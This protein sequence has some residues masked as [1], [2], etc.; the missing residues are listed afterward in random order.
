MR[1]DAASVDATTLLLS[2][3]FARALRVALLATVA[4]GCE[5]EPSW[6]RAADGFVRVSCAPLDGV[7]T[8]RP[9]D[10]LALR[11]LSVDDWRMPLTLAERGAPC[12]SASDADGCGAALSAVQEL[13]EGEDPPVLPRAFVSITRGDEVAHHDTPEELAG[14]L[15]S[16]DH[17][18]EAVLAARV[19]GHFVTCDEGLEQG[20]VRSV[21][22]GFE[23]VAQRYLS[24]CPAQRERVLMHV[25]HDGAVQALDR[26]EVR[27]TGECVGRRPEGLLSTA[28][29][30]GESVLGDF[31]AHLAHL[32]AASVHAFDVLARELAALGAPASLVRKAEEAARDE[33]RHARQMAGLARRFGGMPSEPVVEA[34]PQRD[35]LALARDNAVEGCVRETYGAAVGAFQAAR[36]SDAAVRRIMRGI[37][38]DELRHASLAWQIAAWAEPQ[39]SGAEVAEL[40]VLQTRAIAEL[41]AGERGAR[42]P[43]L[44]ATAGLPDA[45]Q[46]M[47]LL[48]ALVRDLWPAVRG[49]A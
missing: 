28:D 3:L 30:P 20:A 31:F 24:T 29:A 36:S 2:R 34:R 19:S 5:E 23:V 39:L 27:A 7:S 41:S 16:I 26:A 35:L 1:C 40:R 42:A 11:E 44:L 38:A 46:S 22:D 14:L 6:P 45:V 37:A 9:V 21:A 33:V 47:E 17:P 49:A 12:A 13:F 48:A 43:Q 4:T 10:Y 8:A 25:G 15:G 18:N 32:E